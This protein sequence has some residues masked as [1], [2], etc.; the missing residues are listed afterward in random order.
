MHL[1][2]GM[3]SVDQEGNSGLVLVRG[4]GGEV[5]DMARGRDNTV[6]DVNGVGIF[7]GL[8]QSLSEKTEGVPP[9]SLVFGQDSNPTDTHAKRYLR[10][11]FAKPPKIRKI[12]DHTR[13]PLHWV[14]RKG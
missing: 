2:Y 8:I 5:A 7:G 13:K 10:E 11:F 1:L 6:I 12:S 3:V 14:N 4:Q 9:I